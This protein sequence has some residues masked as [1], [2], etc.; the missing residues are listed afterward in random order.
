GSKQLKNQTRNSLLGTW[1][2]K[3]KDGSYRKKVVTHFTEQLSFYNAAGE[4]VQ[5]R[6][7]WP[8]RVEIIDQQPRF[9]V[10]APDGGTWNAAINVLNGK[11]YEQHRAIWNGR[12][13]ESDP[14]VYWVYERS[15]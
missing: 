4:L 11:W 14:N 1:V 7:P 3:N 9:T 10:Y 13:T 2:H 5:K 6:K 12:W 15:E 8:M